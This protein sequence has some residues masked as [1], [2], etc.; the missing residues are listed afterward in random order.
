MNPASLKNL[1]RG[2]Q[3]KLRTCTCCGEAKKTSGFTHNP[4]QGTYTPTCRSCGVWL[5]L[6][7]Q[8]FGK[9]RDW[10][11]NRVKQQERERIRRIVNRP[12][13]VAGINLWKAWNQ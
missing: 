7:R 2:G 13:N 1:K 11:H 10:E 9:T 3:V 4:K 6:F 8:V 5:F 12:A